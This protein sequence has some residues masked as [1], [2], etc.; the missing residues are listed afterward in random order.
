MQAFIQVGLGEAVERRETLLA[1]TSRKAYIDELEQN[2]PVRLVDDDPAFASRTSVRWLARP[3]PSRD[4]LAR[5]QCIAFLN[6]SLKT[7]LAWEEPTLWRRSPDVMVAMERSL[8]HHGSIGAGTCTG[9]GAAFAAPAGPAA[10]S[11]TG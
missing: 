7:R 8:D 5:R 9:H 3:A 10:C 2:A 4:G 6:A 1:A 11:L